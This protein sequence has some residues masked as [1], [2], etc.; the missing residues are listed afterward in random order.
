[1]YQELNG[2]LNITMLMSEGSRYGAAAISSIL[3]TLPLGQTAL[4]VFVIVA[5]IFIATTYDSA[6][7]TLASVSTKRLEAGQNP[8]RWNRVFWAFALGI[9][10]VSLLFVDGALKV[11]LSAT[12]VVSLPLLAVGVLMAIRIKF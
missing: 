4:V 9:L 7:Y 3:L 8:A 10:P 5:L 1:M 6:S 2:H 12:I 11:I